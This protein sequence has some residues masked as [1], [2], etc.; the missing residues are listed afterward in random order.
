MS[1]D[2]RDDFFENR[3]RYEDNR[4]EDDRYE[5]DRDAFRISE[6][7]QP[8]SRTG[9][10]VLFWIAL[11]LGGGVALC[12]VCC[13]GAFLLYESI[14]E[15]AVRTQFAGDPTVHEHI[16]IL[17]SVDF[18]FVGTG[19]EPGDDTQVF[20]LVGDKGTATLVVEIDETADDFVF[21]SSFLRLPNGQVIPMQE[22]GETLQEVFDDEMQNLKDAGR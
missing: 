14:A 13:G 12:C 2:R 19:N 17:Q 4:Y 9:R 7:A 21:K 11:I 6:R 10:S 16:G 22:D 5:D 18:D 15:D 20:Q 8:R 3:D 1:D